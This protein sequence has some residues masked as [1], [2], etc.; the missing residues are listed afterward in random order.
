MWEALLATR[1]A[2]FQLMLRRLAPGLF[3]N[4]KEPASGA[5]MHE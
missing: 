3:P 2:L 1:Y 5:L 4:L